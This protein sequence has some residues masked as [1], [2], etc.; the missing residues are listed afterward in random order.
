MWGIILF[1]GFKNCLRMNIN[2]LIGRN[3]VL[4]LSLR[5]KVEESKGYFE[6]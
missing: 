1:F 6:N 4:S 2:F 3:F 5:I